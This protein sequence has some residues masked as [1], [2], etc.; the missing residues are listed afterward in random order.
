[1]PN[2][3]TDQGKTASSHERVAEKAK[4]R[5]AAADVQIAGLKEKGAKERDQ[6]ESPMKDGDA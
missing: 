4:R 1:M 2:R 3:K 5:F 6:L